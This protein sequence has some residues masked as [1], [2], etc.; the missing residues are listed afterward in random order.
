MCDTEGLKTGKRLAPAAGTP[1]L[2]LLSG[3]RQ[4]RGRRNVPDSFTVVWHWAFGVENLYL[5]IGFEIIWLE[6]GNVTPVHQNCK[7]FS[8]GSHLP[9]W[10][11]FCAG[12]VWGKESDK[13]MV[14]SSEL[15]FFI[16]KLRNSQCV[17]FWIA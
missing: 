10:K 12:C 16:E 1:N 8:Q 2:P 3:K 13:N 6:L 7:N 11:Q 5:H 4:V 15:P 14:E 9:T 17:I